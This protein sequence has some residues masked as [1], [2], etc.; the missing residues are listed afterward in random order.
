ML[1]S[2]PVTLVGAYDGGR[3]RASTVALHVKWRLHDTNRCTT[4]CKTGCSTGCIVFMQL[5]SESRLAA[6]AA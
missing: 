6:A 1:L 3:R 2:D 4:G 5:Y